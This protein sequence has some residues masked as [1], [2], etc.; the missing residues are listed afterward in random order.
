MR[1]KWFALLAFSILLGT[2]SN[3]EAKELKIGYVDSDRLLETNDD[4]KQARQKLQEE[5]RQYVAQATTMEDA[6]KSMADE[7]KAQSLM[8]SEEARREREQRF[9]EKQQELE[10]FRRET[11]GEGGKLYA[12]NIELSKPVLDKIN[13][14]IQKV[15]QEYS[16][17]F[18]FDAGSGNILFALPE[19]DITEKVL[20]ELKKE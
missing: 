9:L 4:Y 7:L 15:S 1:A 20:D 19:Y 6:L 3:L 11:W 13:A 12:R 8:L 16:Y 2:T 5:E 18:V 14:A 17:D 10:K